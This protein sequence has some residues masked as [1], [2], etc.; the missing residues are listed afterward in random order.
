M[1][2]VQGRCFV[3]EAI[4]ATVVRGLYV[5]ETKA[6]LLYKVDQ[7]DLDDTS[8]SKKQDKQ[9][10]NLHL[11]WSNLVLKLRLSKFIIWSSVVGKENKAIHIKMGLKC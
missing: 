3:F 7:L 8:R 4:L 11:H 1:L 9:A 5:S 2:K 10:I 6:E